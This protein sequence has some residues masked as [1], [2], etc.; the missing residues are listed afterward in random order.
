[1]V[2]RDILNDIY[3]M[4]LVPEEFVFMGGCK[5]MKKDLVFCNLCSKS[6]DKSTGYEYCPFCGSELVEE[7]YNHLDDYVITVYR[8]YEFKLE[9]TDKAAA[10]EV[11]KFID[12]DKD[13]ELVST[14][15]QIDKVEDRMEVSG[16]NKR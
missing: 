6:Y 10:R 16:G 3:N 11:L 9:S 2:P 4:F 15:V 7:E 5:D 12:I 14:D 13:M 1:M 8:T